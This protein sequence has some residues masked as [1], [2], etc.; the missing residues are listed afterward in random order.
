MLTERKLW[1]EKC[2]GQ[3]RHFQPM[4]IESECKTKNNFNRFLLIILKVTDF[5]TEFHC[6]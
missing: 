1:T 3:D 2:G 4:L 6:F 5:L